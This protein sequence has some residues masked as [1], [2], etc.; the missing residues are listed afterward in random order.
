[1]KMYQDG[2]E[3]LCLPD[4]SHCHEDELGRNPLDMEFKS[5]S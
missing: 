2:S 3:V 4:G 5:N 1:M